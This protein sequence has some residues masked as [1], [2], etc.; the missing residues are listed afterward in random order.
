MA[1]LLSARPRGRLVLLP[2]LV[3]I[4]LA[5]L[6]TIAAS[7]ALVPIVRHGAILL[8]A[9]PTMQ[10]GVEALPEVKTLQACILCRNCSA[11]KPMTRFYGAEL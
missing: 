7:A 11:A 5:S 2:V 4:G 9:P 6:P 3:A 10:R 8:R 1:A